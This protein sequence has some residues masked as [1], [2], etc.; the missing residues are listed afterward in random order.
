MQVNVVSAFCAHSSVYTIIMSAPAV[1]EANRK[2]DL[3]RHRNQCKAT[4]SKTP[5]PE[6]PIF[7]PFPLSG[8]QNPPTP[9][10][11]GMKKPHLLVL[12]VHNGPQCTMSQLGRRW[13]AGRYSMVQTPVALLTAC[14]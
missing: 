9:T 13:Y 10:T 11:E 14:H 5:K 6:A 4:E 3:D 2:Q 12:R 7:R 8:P 1:L